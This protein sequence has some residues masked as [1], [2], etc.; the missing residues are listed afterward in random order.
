MNTKTITS[1]ILRFAISL[2][3][4]AV[5]IY[6][7]RDGL[8][9]MIKTLKQTSLYFFALGAII[10]VFS[11]LLASLRLRVFLRLQG[12]KMGVGDV[13]RINLIGYFFSSFLPTSIGGDIVKAVYISRECGKNTPAYISI[14]IDRFIGMFTIV[15]IAAAAVFVVKDTSGLHLVC[16]LPV[17]IALSFMFIII[18]Y[19]KKFTKKFLPLVNFFIPP[20]FTHGIRD[21]YNAMHG[22]RHHGKEM[23]GCFMLS[24]AGQ[25]IAF[26][27]V[28]FLA[29]GIKSYVSLKVALLVMP[30]ASIVSMLPS[31]NGMGPREVSIVIML[32]PFIGASAAGAIAF[33]WLG[34][35][36]LTSAIGGIVYMFA[37]HYRINIANIDE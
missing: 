24:L 13:F 37:G 14:F 36:L 18:L 4:M 9:G 17:L 26:T 28:Y 20:K 32:K 21:I 31:I 16:L 15:L 12:I 7:M 8:P 11:I 22:Y 35:L 3:L 23:A 25:I 29:L 30:V 33:L 10:Y 34:L 6:F 2:V 27:A 5:L 19:N 1:G